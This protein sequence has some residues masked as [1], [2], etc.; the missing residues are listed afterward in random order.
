MGGHVES[1]VATVL[2]GMVKRNLEKLRSV[3]EI[4]K[5]INE[6]H[7]QVDEAC[8]DILARQAP[9]ASSLRLVIA[10]LKMSTDLERMGDQAVNI[11]QNAQKYLEEK[12]V[13]ELISIPRMGQIVKGMIRN[14]LDSFITQDLA[15]A[16]SIMKQEEEV[17]ALKRSVFK[18]LVDI[19][20]QQ[21]ES[22][23]AALDLILI[24]RNLERLGDHATNIAEDVIFFLT[25]EDI[26]HQHKIKTGV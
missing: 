21:P 6:F 19:M 3:F 23:V 16:Q 7:V 13:K 17:N 20:M 22:V 26:R 1:A 14:C 10:T 18:E 8:V 4:E 2:E 11:S 15:L 12:P 5:K 24:S 25:G 9:L